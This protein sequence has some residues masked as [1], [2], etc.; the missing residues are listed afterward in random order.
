MRP[1]Y[2]IS[3]LSLL[4]LGQCIDR[5]DIHLDEGYLRIPLIDGYLTDSEG[6]HYVKL[7]YVKSPTESKYYPLEGASVLLKDNRG[8]DWAFFEF[9][10]GTY[11]L[12]SYVRAEENVIYSLH[13]AI[14]E[15][16]YISSDIS[17][18]KNPPIHSIG[19][20][21]DSIRALDYNERLAY[22]KGITLTTPIE[23][24]DKEEN[25]YL[26]RV[27]PTYLFIAEKA[28]DMSPGKRCYITDFDRTFS[29]MGD[30]AG[31]Y[32]H[33]IS[34]YPYSE[35]F[36]HNFSFLVRQFSM[37]KEAFD[38]WEKV[39]YQIENKGGLF[40]RPGFTIRGNMKHVQDES[41]QM[42]GLFTVYSL[43]EQR[44]FINED[45]LAHK[46]PFD[47]H[48]CFPIVPPTPPDE[49]PA[50]C[51]DC[52]FKYGLNVSIIKPDWWL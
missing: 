45:Q 37:T 25:Y 24:P 20:K 8:N 41:K 50:E 1:V 6:P 27:E 44:I 10:A 48:Y 46:I 33:G 12:P 22:Q 42:L 5:I 11:V 9:Q 23:N 38:F 4:F 3:L 7:S 26:F 32:D 43:S 17:L 49:I 2:I 28:G 34:F 35:K 29:I 40:D 18:R 14:G 52:R 19:F 15:D 13:V 31:G 30:R 36:R 21:D 51:F 39:L 16:Q 47:I